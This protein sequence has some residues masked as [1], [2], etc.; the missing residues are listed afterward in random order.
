MKIVQKQYENN[1]KIVRKCSEKN[2][3]HRPKIVQNSPTK[4][5]NIPKY[6]DNFNGNVLYNLTQWLSE[7]HDLKNRITLVG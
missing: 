2:T 3:V 6:R 1:M 7:L 4:Y 5:E